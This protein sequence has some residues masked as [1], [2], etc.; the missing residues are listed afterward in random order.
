MKSSLTRAIGANYTVEP[1]KWTNNLHSS[2]RLEVF[3]INLFQI[4][5]FICLIP[6]RQAA[7]LRDRLGVKD[8]GSRRVKG[9]SLARTT[10]LL[11]LIVKCWM[12]I[13]NDVKQK[14]IY[15]YICN[16]TRQYSE[17]EAKMY[18]EMRTQ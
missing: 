10:F 14:Y 4:T 3:N 6:S 15:I 8:A 13:D 2:P 7:N 12:E 17:G 1:H 11:W 9:G 18:I 5:H 16:V